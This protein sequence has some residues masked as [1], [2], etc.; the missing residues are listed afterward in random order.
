MDTRK[1]RLSD[2]SLARLPFAEDSKGYLVIDQK[3]PGFRVKVGLHT[4]TFRLQ[5]DVF[6]SNSGNR[7]NRRTLSFALGKW[8]ATKSDEARRRAKAIIDRRDRGEPLTGPAGAVTLAEAWQSYEKLLR[9]KKRSDVTIEDYRDKVE[10]CMSRLLFKPMRDIARTAVIELHDQ[11]STSAPYQANAV[12]RVGS[13]IWNHAAKDLEV[14]GLAA[15]NPFRLRGLAN[16]ETPRQS[17]MSEHDLGRWFDQVV[18][19]S[20]PVMREYQFMVL[21]TGRR[22][23]AVATMRWTQINVRSRYVE[24]P[25]T[26]GHEKPDRIPLSKPM[27]RSLWRVR[28]AGRILCPARSRTWVFPSA[29]SESGRIIEPKGSSYRTKDGIQQKITRIAT[30]PHALRH[31]WITLAPRHINLVYSKILIGHKIAG[32]I[33]LSY[34]TVRSMFD[35]LREPQSKFQAHLLAHLGQFP[36]RALKQLLLADVAAAES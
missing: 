9:K 4:K 14:L 13:A 25:P 31:T 19:L 3:L 16:R 32:D 10:R 30:S 15:L 1:I 8:P 2:T 5:I 7:R 23:E 35:Q 33:H 28:R 36:E 11:I 18:T 34:M 29:R 6:D 17:G 20:N 22:R 26:K 24:F 12:L 27:L 21:L